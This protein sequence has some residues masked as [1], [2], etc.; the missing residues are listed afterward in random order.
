M[1]QLELASCFWEDPATLVADGKDEDAVVRICIMALLAAGYDVQINQD[2]E[3]VSW[4]EYG[5]NDA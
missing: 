2:G 5:V 4:E 3:L 1:I